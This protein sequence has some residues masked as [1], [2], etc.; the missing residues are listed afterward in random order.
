MKPFISDFSVSVGE[1][2]REESRN[3]ERYKQRRVKENESEI[4]LLRF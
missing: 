3:E 4:L 1:V 2:G